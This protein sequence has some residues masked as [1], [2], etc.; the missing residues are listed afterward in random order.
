MLVFLK[1]SWGRIPPDP[2]DDELVNDELEMG[3]PDV[4]N[5][6]VFLWSASP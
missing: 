3:D 6:K 1:I 5:M 2:D 4:N